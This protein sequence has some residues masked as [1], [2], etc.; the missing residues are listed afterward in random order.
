MTAYANFVS[1]FPGR[2]RDVLHLYDSSSQKNGYDVTFLLS[3][4]TTGVCVPYD[5]LRPPSPVFG[6]HPSGDRDRFSCAAQKFEDLCGI[7]FLQSPLS[8]PL[9][10]SWKFGS[11]SSTKGD[12]DS[13]KELQNATSV[14]EKETCRDLLTV[15]RNALAHG[16]IFIRDDPISE[17]VLI[18]Q[19]KPKK[20]TP[21]YRFLIVTPPSLRDFLNRWLDFLSE[22]IIPEKPI[23]DEKAPQ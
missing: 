5:R 19:T 22:L 2:C 23:G 8:S 15:I 7:S 11:L 18:S 13:W 17:L 20:N 6:P 12:P 16:N 1:D 4:A 3:I 10:N 21:P 9:T 14:S